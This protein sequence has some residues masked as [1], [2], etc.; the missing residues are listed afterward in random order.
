[1]SNFAAGQPSALH[2]STALPV[3]GQ[4]QRLADTVSSVKMMTIAAPYG[5]EAVKQSSRCW[6][7]FSPWAAA[8]NKRG[9]DPQK[10][11]CFSSQKLHAAVSNKNSKSKQLIS[12][13]CLHRDLVLSAFFAPGSGSFF[14]RS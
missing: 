14:L 12:K 8:S 2:C 10:I 1:M 7:V 4:T 3:G 9:P 13:C 5:A 6:Q 11:Q